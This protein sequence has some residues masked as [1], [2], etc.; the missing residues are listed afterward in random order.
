MQRFFWICLAGAAGTGARYLVA[1]WSAPRFG[2]AFPY[3][4]LIVNLVGCF[5]IAAVMYAALALSWSP[6]VRSAIAIWFYRRPYHLFELQLRDQPFD[7]AR[8]ARNCCGERRGDDLWRV[9]LR[10][11]R[12]AVRPATAWPLRSQRSPGPGS[13]RQ[14]QCRWRADLQV[15]RQEGM[16]R[17]LDGNQ[18]LVKDLSRRVG[19]VPSPPAFAGPARA[20]PP[21]GLRGSDGDPRRRRLRCQQCDPHRQPDRALERSSGS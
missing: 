17:V 11:D 19:P 6:T 15:R 9:R 5:A 14:C 20:S 21:R 4:T 18:F 8:R 12:D 16:M 3:G 1:L 7:R 2:S 10:V 13:G